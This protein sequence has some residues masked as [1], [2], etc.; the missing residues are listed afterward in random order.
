MSS[1]NMK[2]STDLLPNLEAFPPFFS[3]LSSIQLTE[4]GMG[5]MEEKKVCRETEDWIKKEFSL[6]EKIFI[7]CKNGKIVF[8]ISFYLWNV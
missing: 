1:N 4:N 8:L 3:A 5:M 6:S 7:H 2:T